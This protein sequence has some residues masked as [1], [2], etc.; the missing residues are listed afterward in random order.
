MTKATFRHNSW[1]VTA[2]LTAVA[3][4]Y[5]TLVWLS[6]RR[7]VTALEDQVES[8]RR[9]AA[10]AAELSADLAGCQ[11]E[12]DQA[13]AAVARWEKAAPR[14]RHL[15]AFFEK[16][17]VM[18]NK[19]GLAVTRF[20]PQPFVA[21]EEIRE[22]PVVIDCSGGFAHVY[23]FLRNVERLPPTIWVESIKIEKAARDAKNVTCKVDLVGFAD[24]PSPLIGEVSKGRAEAASQAGAAPAA[25]V[26]SAPAPPS[27]TPATSA[28]SS[29]PSWRQ[30]SQWM[31]NDP[32][33]TL[34]PPLGKTRDPFKSP[35]SGVSQ[36]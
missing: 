26:Q 35:K 15:A 14:K 21:H 1:T 18:A 16:I 20:D 10:Q 34:A 27:A 4:A 31:Q 7:A 32:R 6:G 23:E 17:N 9:F 30:V 29:R 33:T 5:L 36:H 19:A 2:L 25:A 11:Q 22:I 28:A 12:L 13:Q 8:K 24:D 3:V